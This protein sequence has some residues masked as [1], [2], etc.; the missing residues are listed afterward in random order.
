MKGLR[1]KVGENLDLKSMIQKSLNAEI[2]QLNLKYALFEDI[3]WTEK[4]II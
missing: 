1:Y 3:I 4:L 2:L